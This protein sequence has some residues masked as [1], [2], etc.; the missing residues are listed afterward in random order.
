M[1][2]QE[3]AF[4]DAYIQAAEG[5]HEN[6]LRRAIAH[7]TLLSL[8]RHIH[9]STRIPSRRHLTAAMLTLCETR[10]QPLREP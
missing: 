4:R 8:V 9:I 5:F 2:A 7:Y 6:H 3:T 1:S 10:L